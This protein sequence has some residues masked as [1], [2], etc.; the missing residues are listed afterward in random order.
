MSLHGCQHITQMP[1]TLGKVVFEAPCARCGSLLKWTAIRS[2]TMG[3][4]EWESM[5]EN[6]EE[7]QSII[8]EPAC[9]GVG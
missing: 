3:T 5:P 4:L 2:G 6:G 8:C 7:T 9:N 1:M